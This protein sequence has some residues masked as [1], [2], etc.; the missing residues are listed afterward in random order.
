MTTFHYASIFVYGWS[1]LW[2]NN[3][4]L[5]FGTL[6]LLSPSGFLVHF[7]FFVVCFTDRRCGGH[8]TRSL[9][10]SE[11]RVWECSFQHHLGLGICFG[12]R[13]HVGIAEMQMLLVAVTSRG[14]VSSLSDH[15]QNIRATKSWICRHGTPFKINVPSSWRG[16]KKWL[17]THL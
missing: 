8:L 16:W 17:E 15:V 13:V 5:L 1:P 7:D 4:A 12:G 10:M 6:R 9:F 2:G 14:D 3:V 11:D